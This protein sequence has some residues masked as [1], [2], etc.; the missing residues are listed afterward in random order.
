MAH[1][2]SH[3]HFVPGEH[4]E[5]PKKGDVYRCD[6]CGM[7]MKVTSDCHCEDEHGP[8]LDCCHQPLRRV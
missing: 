4:I 3:E 5:L 6:V 2:Q 8:Q 1:K 7:E